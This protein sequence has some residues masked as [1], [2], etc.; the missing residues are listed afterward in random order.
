[1]APSKL[2]PESEA[3]RKA[4]ADLEVLPLEYRSAA[5]PVLLEHHLRSVA[6]SGAR[7]VG[8]RPA[9]STRAV[10]P[11]SS[12]GSVDLSQLVELWRPGTRPEWALLSAYSLTGDSTTTTVTGF[13]VNKEL[14]NQGI[15]IDIS[16]EIQKNVDAQPA[17]M[18]Q[19]KKH[20]NTAQAKKE[21][22]LTREGIRY[23]SAKLR[24]TEAASQSPRS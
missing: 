16:K 6:L 4:L 19:V 14:R 20:G 21:Y 13:Q 5:F 15:I 24:P 2:T 1:M 8:D 12:K 17:L 10:G 7:A 18:L 22:R 9:E 3:V 23:L 11:D